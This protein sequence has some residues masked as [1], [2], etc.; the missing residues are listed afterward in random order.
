MGAI[1]DIIGGGLDIAN[2]IQNSPNKQMKRTKQL[3]DIQVQNQEKL[4]VQAQE[5]AM[6]TWK[7]TNY[8]AQIAMMKEA[9]INPALMYGSAGSGGSTNAG[10]GGSAASGQSPNGRTFDLMNLIAMKQISADVE[11]KKSETKL[12]NT[13][14]DV[15]GSIGKGKGQAEIDNLIAQT[16]NETLKGE[17]I[18]VQTLQQQIQN[19]NTQDIIDANL[20]NIAASTSKLLAEGN[21]TRDNAQNIINESAAKAVGQMFENELTQ[22]KIKLTDTER[23]NIKTKAQQTWNELGIR[24]WEAGIK[25]FEAEIKAEYPS[26]GD[27]FG[28]I[29]KKAYKSVKQIEIKHPGLFG[30]ADYKDKVSNYNK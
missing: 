21:L 5:L 4:N 9:G 24:G 2:A 12:N 11:L 3:M 6:K 8:P 25:N 17:L 7:E 13:N 26:A 23:E 20:D 19:S 1:G 10:S 22:A 30:G 28:A 16:K 27:V 15:I 18:K 14:A 29:L